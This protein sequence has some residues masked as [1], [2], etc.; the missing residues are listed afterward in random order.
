MRDAQLEGPIVRENPGS[1]RKMCESL[2]L[3]ERAKH[4]NSADDL[5]VPYLNKIKDGWL[6]HCKCFHFQTK[7]IRIS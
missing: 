2:V 5:I 1:Y 7:Y 6:F 3:T 4:S